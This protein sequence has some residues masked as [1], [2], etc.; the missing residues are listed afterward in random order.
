MEA[1]MAACSKDFQARGPQ[2]KAH[3][4]TDIRAVQPIGLVK[5]ALD[6]QGIILAWGHRSEA[7][8]GY[9]KGELVG[10]HVST[11]LPQLEGMDLVLEDRINSRIAFL[12]HC[13]MPFTVRHR[14]G[15]RFSSELFINRLGHQNVVMLV[16]SLE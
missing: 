4:L 14:D 6:D 7:V 3:F 10:H 12:C 5:L 16:C 8:F 1:I 9:R 11:L 13:A 2:R 15:N